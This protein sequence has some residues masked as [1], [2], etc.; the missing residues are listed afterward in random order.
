V[1]CAFGIGGKIGGEKVREKEHLQNS[2][3]DENLDENDLPQGS[4]YHHG[5]E[6]VTVKRVHIAD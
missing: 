2:E 4:A 6:T 3:H 5:T 1:I